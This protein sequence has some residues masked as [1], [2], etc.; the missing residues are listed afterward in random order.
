MGLVRD[1][2]GRRGGWDDLTG[3]FVRQNS[4]PFL[5]T[6]VFAKKEIWSGKTE[7][8][9]F[10][11][12]KT[13]GKGSVL[14]LSHIHFLLFLFFAKT[15]EQQLF[16]PP[17]PLSKQTQCTETETSAF[18]IRLLLLLLLHVTKILA[19]FLHQPR[20]KKPLVGS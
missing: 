19:F 7:Q 13:F 17:A 11:T 2:V 18:F 3:I 6:F 5:L 12:N 10:P 16:L 9:R 15:E 8:V 20:L 14:S 4:S 1:G